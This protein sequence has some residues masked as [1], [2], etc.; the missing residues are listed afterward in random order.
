MYCSYNRFTI[1]HTINP[2]VPLPKSILGG[3]ELS[4]DLRDEEALT[5][6][7]FRLTTSG[8]R[9]F[10]FVCGLQVSSECI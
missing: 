7:Y 4:V 1:V 2:L 9:C 3:P 5:E 6:D 10:V 8:L